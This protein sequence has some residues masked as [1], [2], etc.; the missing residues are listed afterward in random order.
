[1]KKALRDQS[2]FFYEF[3]LAIFVEKIYLL[4]L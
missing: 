3:F 1:M 2:L 4:S